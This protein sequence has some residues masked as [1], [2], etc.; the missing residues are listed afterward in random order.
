[1]TQN[2]K[3]LSGRSYG[4]RYDSDHS[5]THDFYKMD[6]EEVDIMYGKHPSNSCWGHLGIA[7]KGRGVSTLARMVW[8]TFFGDDV[9]KSAPLSAGEGEGGCKSYLGNAQM[10]PAC[11]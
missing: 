1:M 11:I 8:G 5:R 10:P 9:P 6:E 2:S 7:R 3:D 4:L